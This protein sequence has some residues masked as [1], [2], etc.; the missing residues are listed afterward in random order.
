M[1]MGK[2][3][4]LVK[5][6]RWLFLLSIILM[7]LSS[8]YGNIAFGNIF[9]LLA[10]LSFAAWT[11]TSSYKTT[12][13]M[14][15]F[16]L[17]FIFT[18]FRLAVA[19][20]TTSYLMLLSIFMFASSFL[21]TVFSPILPYSKILFKSLTKFSHSLKP[22]GDKLEEAKYYELM[23]IPDREVDIHNLLV[24]KMKGI[25]FSIIYD[26]EKMKTYLVTRGADTELMRTITAGIPG[27]E[28]GQVKPLDFEADMKKAFRMN[29]FPLKRRASIKTAYEASKEFEHRRRAGFAD[30]FPSLR[31]MKAK[32]LIS[33]IPKERE[34]LE[35]IKNRYE[36]ELSAIEHHRGR[37]RPAFPFTSI[38][39]QT[40]RVDYKRTDEVQQAGEILEMC[41][42]ALLSNDSIYS[43]NLTGFG[44]DSELLKKHI[45]SK[46]ITSEEK[47]KIT[48]ELSHALPHGE[49]EILSGEYA[50]S[51]IHFAPESAEENVV[52]DVAPLPESYLDEGLHL[53]RELISGVGATGKEVCFDHLALNRHTLIT[54]QQGAG[55]TTLAA[56]IASDCLGKGIPAIIITPNREWARLGRASDKILVVKAGSVP[57]NLVRVPE[58]VPAD[59]FR[60]QLAMHIA[61][62]MNA[63]PYTNPLQRTLLNAFRTLY[64]KG[65]EPSLSDVYLAANEAIDELFGVHFNKAVRYDKYGQNLFS[66]LENIR[67]L[68]ENDNF[69]RDGVRIEDCFERGAVFDLSGISKMLRPL[70][71]SFIL[72]QVFSYAQSR[73]DEEG[74][75]E[76]RL[77]VVMEEAHQTFRKESPESGK[78][79]VT[80]EL[81]SELGAFRKHGVG[82]ILISHFADQL[83]EGL[84]RHCQNHFAFKQDIRGAKLAV[85]QL[86]FD[87]GDRQLMASAQSKILKLSQGEAC[88]LLTDSERK[89]IGPFFLRIEPQFLDPLEPGV[90]DER[91]KRYLD[92]LGIEETREGKDE[93]SKNALA[94]LKDINGQRFSPLTKRYERLGFNAYKGKTAKDELIEKELITEVNVSAGRKSFIFI[95]PTGKGTQEMQAHDLE[96]VGFWADTRVSFKHRLYQEAVK[97]AFESEGCHVVLEKSVGEGGFVDA[98]AYPKGHAD[99]PVAIEITLSTKNAVGNISKALTEFQKV[100]IVYEDNDVKNKVADD[101]FLNLPLEK[102]K[103]VEYNRIDDYLKHLD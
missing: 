35:E 90:A 14:F 18:I 73:F 5:N 77:L 8:I 80:E 11:A 83:S 81:E 92:A 32:L 57:I 44:T 23:K 6:S 10:V 103:Q 94:L 74:E 12:I 61:N 99:K 65:S 50:S 59:I 96:D 87:S 41:N 93:L 84:W 56:M 62:G 69:Q 52:V 43:V 85:E 82:L 26:F 89:S 49:G 91:M 64:K 98:A 42:N 95:I 28:F 66:S 38:Y 71:Y 63:G 7:L 39:D 15:S 30:L 58:G 31:N 72:S 29:A 13:A 46:M 47:A 20:T 25:P 37:S 16:G 45:S 86:A 51:F 9:F 67:E 76:L 40:S 79:N 102:L 70:V 36:R 33:F 60:Q 34:D 53:G 68:L 54:G 27:L 24:R 3:K 19:N 2:I 21:I 55:K 4:W 48:K 78:R 88:C 101:A 75:N 17:A 100:I 1:L 97:R 22:L